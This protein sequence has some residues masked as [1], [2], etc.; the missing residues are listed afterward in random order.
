MCDKYDNMMNNYPILYRKKFAT[1]HDNNS[2]CGFSCPIGWYEPINNLSCKLETLNNTYIKDGVSIT[3]AQAKEKFGTLRFYYNVNILPKQP[4]RF[5][6]NIIDSLL[7]LFSKVNYNYEYKNFKRLPRKNKFL[8]K[9]QCYLYGLFA[10]FYYKKP[11]QKQDLI[12]ESLEHEVSKLVCETEN[13][14][15]GLCQNCGC[16]IGTE[17][18]PRYKTTGWITYICKKCYSEYDLKSQDVIKEYIT[19]RQFYKDSKELAEN[20]FKSDWQPQLILPLWRGGSVPG[21]VIDEYLKYE[22]WDIETIPMYVKSYNKDNESSKEVQY[23]CCDDIF[24][25]IK[26]KNINRILIVDD[27]FDTGNTVNNVINKLGKD[28][29]IKIATVYWKQDKCT[30]DLKPDYFIRKINKES[31]VIFPHE[32]T[33][34]Y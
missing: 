13:E 15:L 32:E 12:R 28:I 18:S 34:Y 6:S 21:I 25:Y 24:K 5:I 4:Y 3:L 2:C 26:E 33:K 1:K 9:I 29:D 14:C 17:Y 8:F 16:T 20:I 19:P 30:L 27:I 23:I 7:C 22:E 31:W 11:T 10:Y